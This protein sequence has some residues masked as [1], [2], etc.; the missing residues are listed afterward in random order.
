MIRCI[1]QKVTSSY[2]DTGNPMHR[3][4]KQSNVD[5]N[6]GKSTAS[7]NGVYGF[8]AEGIPVSSA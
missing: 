5:A 8:F 1:E 6:G 2:P 7:A 3:A 4:G